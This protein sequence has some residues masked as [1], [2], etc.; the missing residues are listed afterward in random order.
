[1]YLITGGAGFIG[2]NIARECLRRGLDVRILDN[3]STGHWSNIRDI[4]EDIEVV[5]G[6]LRSYHI[7][8][9]VMRDVEVV[10]HQGALPSVPRSIADPITTNDVNVQGSLNVLH[11]ALEAGCRRVVFAS[12]SSIYGDAP[13]QVKSEDLHVRPLSPYAVSKLAGEK[14]FQVFNHIYGL[15][16]VALRYFNVFGPHQDPCSPYSAVIP[17][18]TRAFLEGRSPVINGDGEQS[19]DFTFIGNVVHANLLAAEAEEAPG[20]VINV[21]CGD[22][23]TVNRLAGSLSELTGRT[24]V[25]PVHGPARAGDVRHS[26]AD[27]SLARRVLGY[28]PVAGFYEGLE[29]TVR[30]M[31]DGD[32]SPR[33]GG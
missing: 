24:D 18:F 25:E 33:P 9:S 11:A 22:S 32:G 4:R 13:Q 28:E 12:S 30:F 27:I 5:E 7:V 8:Q 1:M 10:F 2:S 29:R 15:E 6:D 23:I 21:A 16:T 3:F 14:Y 20:M 31:R 26:R 17:L 19:R